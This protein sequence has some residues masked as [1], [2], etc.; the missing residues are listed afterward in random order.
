MEHQ[1]RLRMVV[2]DAPA[3]DYFSYHSYRGADPQDE[4][5]DDELGPTKADVRSTHSLTAHGL[6][7]E[8]TANQTDT[9]TTAPTIF[10]ASVDENRVPTPP[11]ACT[12]SPLGAP[13]HRTSANAH[14]PGGRAFC[15]ACVNANYLHRQL[16]A[17]QRERETGQSFVKAL[18]SQEVRETQGRV[19]SVGKTIAQQFRKLKAK[20]RA[21]L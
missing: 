15:N 9:P 20:L 8:R 4:W 18:D 17:M 14:C 19:A 11:T 1:Y 6:D 7:T 13:L 12:T 10:T 16:T 21:F 3:T 2:S 5:P